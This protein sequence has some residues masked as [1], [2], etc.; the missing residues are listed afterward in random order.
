MLQIARYWGHR[1]R[2][3]TTSVVLA[4]GLLIAL[5][6]TGLAA[7]GYS[8]SNQGSTPSPQSR[9]QAQVT[10]P[11]V[12]VQK[13]GV[14]QSLA[15]LEVP[16]SDTGA[17]R[18]ETCLWQAFQHCHPAELVFISS[19]PG[20]ALIRTF[21][22]SSNNGACSISDAR[23]QRIASNPP[24]VAGTYTCTGL[25]QKPGGLL[26]TACGKDGDVLVPAS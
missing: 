4:I 11:P 19:S 20:T 21:T 6:S 18:V 23:Q 12:P 8:G 25:V 7:C 5:A 15:R 1:P 17:E 22:I 10:H 24:S 3:S 14:V 9:P 13:C 2:L 16:P 26:F